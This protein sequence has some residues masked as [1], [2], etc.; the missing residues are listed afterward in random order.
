MAYDIHYYT[1]LEYR[2]R[3]IED[4]KVS[5][6]L[7]VQIQRENL[8]L[9]SLLSSDVEQL[10]KMFAEQEEQIWKLNVE[11]DKKNI[12][13]K[14]MQEENKKDKEKLTDFQIQELLR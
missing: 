6:D 10:N 4:T 9:K 1:V 5:N 13:I 14:H 7:R 3:K 8:H 11:I 12:Y 2:E